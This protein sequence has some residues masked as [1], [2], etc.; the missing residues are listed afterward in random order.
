VAFTRTEHDEDAEIAEVEQPSEEEL[1]MA[2]IEEQNEVI[3]NPELP[4]DEE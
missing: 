3:E 2:E 1:E 4:E